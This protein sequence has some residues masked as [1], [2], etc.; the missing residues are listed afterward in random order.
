LLPFLGDTTLLYSAS[1]I[2]AEIS[3]SLLWTPLEVIKARLQI[4]KT[5]EEG[6][7]LFNLREIAKKEGIRG[8]YRGYGIGLGIYIPFNAVVCIPNFPF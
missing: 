2:I 8:F 5:A 4:S 6:K 3:S 1:G 7:L